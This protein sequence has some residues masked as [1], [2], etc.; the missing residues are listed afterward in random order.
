MREN[1]IKNTIKK[2][3]P[4]IPVFLFAL[5]IVW[6]VANMY[7]TTKLAP[8]TQ[9]INSLNDKIQADQ[10]NLEQHKETNI[11]DFSN[12]NTALAVLQKSITGNDRSSINSRLSRIEGKLGL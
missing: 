3:L 8:V 4:L 1:K 11:Q 2:D 5:N 10:I 9:S 7:L 12:I 6:A